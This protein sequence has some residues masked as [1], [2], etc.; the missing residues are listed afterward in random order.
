MCVD[1]VHV[2]RLAQ[3]ATDWQRYGLKPSGSAILILI[4]K[5]K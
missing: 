4:Y 3:E 2:K 5:L 1:E